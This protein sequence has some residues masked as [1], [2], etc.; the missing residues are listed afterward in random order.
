MVD[1][2]MYPNTKTWNRS[3]GC[4]F[5]C[6]YCKPSFQR[7]LKRVA[8]N[9]GCK[10]CYTYEP[11]D[12]LSRTTIPSSPIVF[13]YGTG[14]IRFYDP[15][16]VRSTF[17]IIDKHKP[18]MKKTYY[19]QSKDPKCFNKYLDWFNANQDKVIL[20]TTLETNR[21]LNYREISKAPY[22]ILR[23][24]NFYNLDYPRKVV[25]IEPVLDFDILEFSEWII[26]L[27]KQ[28]TLEYVWF[29]F[30]SKNCGLPEPTIEKAQTFVNILTREG[31]EVR[32]KTLRGLSVPP[33]LP[34][35]GTPTCPHCGSQRVRIVYK[36][37]EGTE[38]DF[39]DCTWCSHVWKPDNS[40][41]PS[42]TE[43]E[44]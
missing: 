19:F 23:F 41:M 11:H 30:D 5:D 43:K 29:G 21:N 8:Y 14:D 22:P 24:K 6:V 33:P 4:L 18:R 42:V 20:L 38:V 39:Y 2:N 44:K 27:H 3:V 17:E 25:T 16:S 40:S 10:K 37:D 26:R 36:D 35:R 31:I 13:V 12:H 9:I 34:S 32:G 1:S 15:S 28:G 7:Q